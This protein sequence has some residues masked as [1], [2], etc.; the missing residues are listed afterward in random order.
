MQ[1]KM[2]DKHDFWS[3]IVR[4]LFDASFKKDLNLNHNKGNILDLW[5]LMK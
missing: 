5:F 2:F 3:F 1:I 4:S